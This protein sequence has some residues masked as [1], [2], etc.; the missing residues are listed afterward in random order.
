[1]TKEGFEVLSV[2][3]SIEFRTA[4]YFHQ[5]DARLIQD[6]EA[7]RSWTSVG[8]G[9][10]V[11]EAEEVQ[12]KLRELRLALSKQFAEIWIAGHGGRDSI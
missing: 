12:K 4:L 8:A 2:P 9:I 11:H 6:A 3:N 10:N 1:M 5:L 7:F